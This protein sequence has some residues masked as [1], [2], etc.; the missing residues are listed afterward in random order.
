MPP[1]LFGAQYKTTSGSFLQR[2]FAGCDVGPDAAASIIGPKRLLPRT[3]MSGAAAQTW[4]VAH[5]GLLQEAHVVG[6]VEH[7]GHVFDAHLGVDALAVGVDGVHGEEE[8]LCNLGGRQ[9]F[10]T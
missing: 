4:Y 6:L 5:T 1:A 7:F 2:T 10:G 8:A 3:L 9:A